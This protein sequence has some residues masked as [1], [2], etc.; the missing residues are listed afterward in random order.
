MTTPVSDPL[1]AHVDPELRAALASMPQVNFEAQ[2]RN[3]IRIAQP[4]MPDA[5]LRPGIPVEEIS[6]PGPAGAPP[7]KVLVINRKTSSAPRP[8][9]LFMHGGGYIGGSVWRQTFRMQDAAKA[10]DCLVVSVAYRVA[11]ET[12]FPGP[13]DDCYAA[14]QW[15]HAE[16]QQLGIDRE[17]IVLLG[18][19]AGGGLAA[20][21]A[22]LARERDDAPIRGQVLVYPMIDDR[23][24]MQDNVP[25]HIGTHVW[26]RSSN[27]F[28]WQ[29]Y[30]GHEPGG[31]ATTPAAAPA[32]EA[33][34]SQLPPTWIGVGGLDLF[35]T[36]NVDF[37]GRL[38]AAGVA[39]ELLVVP[40]AFHGFNRSAPKAAVSR[41][42]DGAWNN[43][44]AGFFRT[45]G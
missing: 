28:G 44:V 40:G 8:A 9:I 31:E 30:L 38:M 37:A 20:Q 43:A 16:A 4:D 3:G 2:F 13:R 26:T 32:R 25:A 10:H 29:C 12:P 24:G 34:L 1:L 27:R 17:R 15:L 7:I 5:P 18:E 23:T 35:V 14:L 36:E 11:P 45:S 33:D 39:C 22:L 41:Q 21:V 6:I 42:F 19:S